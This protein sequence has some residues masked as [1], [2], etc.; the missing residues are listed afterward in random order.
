[1]IQIQ[2]WTPAARK[3]INIETYE[4]WDTKKVNV[5]R[6][7]RTMNPT[8]SSTKCIMIAWKP[9]AREA[10]LDSKVAIPIPQID[11]I[12]ASV[13]AFLEDSKEDASTAE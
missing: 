2:Y 1:M 10:T 5:W 6:E 8:W 4:G 9:R 3:H 7:D 12:K 11:I 13:E